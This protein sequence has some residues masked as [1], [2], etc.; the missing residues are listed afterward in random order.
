MDTNITGKNSKNNLN[1]WEGKRKMVTIDS[2]AISS[3]II[4]LIVAMIGPAITLE[5]GSWVYHEAIKMV[6]GR[7]SK[8]VD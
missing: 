3:L 7:S 4:S 2:A 8:L 6:F 5:V 1:D